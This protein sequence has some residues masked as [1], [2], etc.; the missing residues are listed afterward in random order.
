MNSVSSFGFCGDRG[1]Q[2]WCRTL[3]E[4]LHLWDWQAACSE[5]VPGIYLTRQYSQLMMYCID[6][7]E[8]LHAHGQ[9][10]DYHDAIA[11]V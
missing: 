9:G 6:L 5:D 1:R 10:S 2:L 8:K 11:A 3:T 7:L 4:A